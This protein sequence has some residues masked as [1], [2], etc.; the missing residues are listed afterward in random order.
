MVLITSV[1]A[2]IARSR[3]DVR[4]IEK[5]KTSLEMIRGEEDDRGDRVASSLSRLMREA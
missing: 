2:R 5:R 4:G 1:S 3:T